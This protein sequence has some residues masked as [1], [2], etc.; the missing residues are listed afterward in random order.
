MCLDTMLLHAFIEDVTALFVSA[1]GFSECFVGL[2]AFERH[3]S[4]TLYN[5]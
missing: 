2:S 3:V 1:I 5:V 4:A